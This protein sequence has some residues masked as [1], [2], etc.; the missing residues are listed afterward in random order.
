VDRQ[1]FYTYSYWQDEV[2][3]NNY[4]K[5]ALFEVVWPKTKAMFDQKPI[6]HS[7]EKVHS[8]L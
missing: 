2:S 1:R 8:L 4:R 7:L 5:S 3:L 6:A